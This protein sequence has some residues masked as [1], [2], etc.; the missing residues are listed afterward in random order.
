[1]SAQTQKSASPEWDATNVLDSDEV[2]EQ[3]LIQKAK[4]RLEMKKKTNT[5]CHSGVLPKRPTVLESGYNSETEKSPNQLKMKVVEIPGFGF[6]P[7]FTDSGQNSPESGSGQTCGMKFSS[8][9][10]VVSGSPAASP[11]AAESRDPAKPGPSAD[12]SKSRPEP[13]SILNISRKCSGTDVIKLFC[14]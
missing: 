2:I 11:V 6:K 7:K 10:S 14:A 9:E 13:R 3:K 4:E 5:S 12:R 1:V 8:P